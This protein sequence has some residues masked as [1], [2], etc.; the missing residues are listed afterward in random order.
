VTT[1]LRMPRRSKR[2][3]ARVVTVG[4]GGAAAAAASPTPASSTC[5]AEHVDGVKAHLT[6]LHVRDAE[7]LAAIETANAVHDAEVERARA[8]RDAA[9]ERATAEH[10]AVRA[11]MALAESELD[12][13]VCAPVS[14]GRD[15]FE[16]LPDELIVKI[17]L[18]LPFEV[19]WGGACDR[20]CLRWARLMESTP[21]QR[22]KRDGRWAAYEAG[23]IKPR[24]L[25]GHTAHVYALAV[26]LDGK[27]YSGSGDKTIRVWSGDDGTH[28]QT[29]VGHTDYVNSLAVGLD[30]KVY[31][32]S[33]DM[34]IRVW[35]GDDGTHLQTL[36]GHTSFVFALAVGLDG[37]VY[38]GSVDKLIR[39][40]SGT[41]GAHLQTLVGHTDVV[42]SLAVGLDGK[43]FSGSD[44]TTIRVWSGDDGTHLQTLV[45]H[46][47]WVSIVAVGLDGK[48]IYSGSW[49]GT[50]R[51]W[52][53]TD[54][55]HI[56]TLVGHTSRV[57][58]LAL[59]LDGKVLSGSDDG[60]IRVWSP[61]GTHLHT[62]MKHND[63]VRVVYALA[64]MR[65]GTLVSG[66]E[67][68]GENEGEY[69]DDDEY[70]ECAELKMW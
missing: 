64:V 8:V 47:R 45:G 16:W 11:E 36:E 15:P 69:F 63:D 28:L 13:L 57:S 35:S 68:G 12:A 29:L 42:T 61:T 41:D 50:I 7:L 43:L 55:T 23:V 18:M 30:G 32:G 58:A 10:K 46:T 44:D 48:K 26:G 67:Y 24:G 17:M 25:H 54:G 5:F 40:W 65:D 56:Q 34:T 31:S 38:S 51:V 33:E 53:G 19:M 60:T 37:K 52:S 2:G 14:G 9:I 22:R 27:V 39:V 3:D 62:L 59:G 20:V 70:V 21:V 6:T 4:S 66:G 1:F 49:D